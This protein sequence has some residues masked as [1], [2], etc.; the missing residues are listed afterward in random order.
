MSSRVRSRQEPGALAEHGEGL[1]QRDQVPRLAGLAGA[2]RRRARLVELRPEA[3]VLGL[4]LHHPADALEV[5]PLVGELGDAPQHLDVG[6]AVAAVAALRPRRQHEAAALVDAQRLGVHA[7][8]LGGDGDDVDGLG[9]TADHDVGSFVAARLAA[10]S[11]SIAARSASDS[12][13]GTTT[14]TVTIRSPVPFFVSMPL[15]ADAVPA[16]RLRAG[17]DAQRDGRAVER[18]HGDVGTEHGVG[19][20]D[21]HADGEVVALAAEPGVRGD[22]DLHEQVAGRPAVAAGRAAALE[23]DRLAVGHAGGDAGLDLA[24]PLLD[25]ACPGTSGR[26]P[27]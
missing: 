21:R 7:G 12:D 25:A 26:G 24:G 15:P 10:A 2:G 4:Q 8:Q 20:A 11:C 9:A 27:R 18:R 19:E 13:V 14:S 22:V 16:A 5:H 6:V 3:L 23:A 1:A 17:L